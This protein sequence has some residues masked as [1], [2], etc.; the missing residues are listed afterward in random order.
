MLSEEIASHT[1]RCAPRSRR[2][3]LWQVGC[4]VHEGKPRRPPSQR[5]DS[6]VPSA[7][8]ERDARVKRLDNDVR[9]LPSVRGTDRGPSPP[10]RG[11]VDRSEFVGE[12]TKDAKL[13]GCEGPD[14]DDL[15]VVLLDQ[16]RMV[17]AVVLVLVSQR[18]HVNSALIHGIAY[19][20][21]RATNLSW[22]AGLV[23]KS[24]CGHRYLARRGG[25][26]PEAPAHSTRVWMT[27]RFAAR[28]LAERVRLRERDRRGP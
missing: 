14:R 3:D 25:H 20:E 11:T 22:M 21:K 1:R 8:R 9:R 15:I 4:Q 5:A 6:L 19:H 13:A 26:V 7:S 12:G 28:T 10:G 18:D 24:H 23:S 2:T 16:V 27:D 17:S